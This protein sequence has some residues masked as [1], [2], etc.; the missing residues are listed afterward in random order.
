MASQCMLVAPRKALN[1]P[2]RAGGARPDPSGEPAE[3]QVDRRCLKGVVCVI[4]EAR[5]RRILGQEIESIYDPSFDASDAEST[6]LAPMPDG[7]RGDR[8]AH[9][10]R[11]GLWLYP[12]GADAP[13]LSHEQEAHLFRKLNY[14][15]YRADKLRRAL[16]P[17]HARAAEFDEIERLQAEALTVKNEI[18]RANLRLVVSIVK[19]RA[20]AGHCLF[21]LASDGNMSLI[22]AVEKF[23]YTRGF[24]FSTYATRAILRNLARTLATERSRHYRFVTGREGVFQA[25]AA[26]CADE[27]GHESG[28][29]GRPE[30]IGRM[31]GR[32]NDRE[33]GVIVSRF[34]LEGARAKT[35]RELGEELGIT[36]QRVRQ[37]EARAR[38]KLREFALE[39][40]LDPIAA[41]CP[42]GGASS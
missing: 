36:R 28:Q 14:L 15:K 8:A 40:G 41:G 16:D 31:L 29:R 26:R 39:Q 4:D 17:A 34:G 3:G 18:I 27:Q 23:D 10:R 7:Q 33:R 1:R 19:P 21:E 5:A 12:L 24:R 25:T 11:N 37:I 13:L 38:E 6:I 42:V 20:R 22:R 32:L 30:A 35:L 2:Q 9:A